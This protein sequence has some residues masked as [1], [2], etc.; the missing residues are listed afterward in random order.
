[1]K[2]KKTRNHCVLLQNKP[3]QQNYGKYK[4]KEREQNNTDY[5]GCLK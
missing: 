1:M 4:A 2:T 5:L 3:K